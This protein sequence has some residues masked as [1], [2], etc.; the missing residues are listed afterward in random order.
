MATCSKSALRISLTYLD[1]LPQYELEKPYEVWVPVV[2]DVPKSNCHFTEHHDI[3]VH[4][5][6]DYDNSAFTLDT[7]GFQY[8]SHESHHLPDSKVLTGPEGE[9]S[10]IPY[11]EETAQLV[12]DI[13]QA[14]KVFTYDWRVSILFL[15]FVCKVVVD[16]A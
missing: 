16:R 2:G 4:N 10:V 12:K 5:I 11:L 3:P 8:L 7:S 14:K 15:C 6:R 13:L 1:D 9:Q